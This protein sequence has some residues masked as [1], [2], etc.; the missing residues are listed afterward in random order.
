M[1]YTDEG[2]YANAAVRHTMTGEWYLSG[3]FNPA[4]NMPVGQVLHRFTFFLFGIGLSS[5]RITTT[6]AFVLMA[7][8]T[9]LFAHRNFGPSAA[10]LTALTLATNYVAFA[11]SRLA[12]ME[13]V[14]ML[15]VIASLLVAAGLKGQGGLA[16]LLISSVLLGAGILTKTISV[17]A[18]PLLAYLA[19]E[20]GTSRRERIAFLAF[21]GL[22]LL[23]VVGSYFLAAKLSFPEDYAYFNQINW[24]ARKHKTLIDWAQG[25]PK[26][27]WRA[28]VLGVSFIGTTGLFTVFA[29]LISR[30]YRR[31]LLIQVMVGYVVAYLAFLSLVSYGPPRCYLPLIVPLA[32]LCA[33]A[34]VELSDWLRK[35]QRSSFAIF[36]IVLVAAVAMNESRHVIAYMSNPSYSFYQMAREVGDIIQEREGKVSDVVLLGHI[37]DSVSLE[38]GTRSVNVM[39]VT[40]DLKWKFKEY[41]PK[42]LLVMSKDDKVLQTAISEGG[43]IMKL[44]SWDVFD[45]YY[46]GYPVELVLLEWNWERKQ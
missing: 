9:S 17:F 18:V 30:R 8:L 1:L 19:W 40:R 12:I 14:A 46:T 27:V 26:T 16:R 11:F 42:Y 22:L 5:A 44:A 7:V 45:N 13:N 21:S 6:V 25:I 35:S 39:Q 37:A 20:Q 32:V 24:E 43:H 2:W 38:I 33:T 31:N 10:M 28:K 34:S 4:I 23:C 36:P 41:R 29:L 3:D 15:F